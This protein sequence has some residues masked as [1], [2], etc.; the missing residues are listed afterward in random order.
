[1][2]FEKPT[3]RPQE[4]GVCGFLILGCLGLEGQ[5]LL[6]EGTQT[7][8]KGYLEEEG[9]WITG[10][11]QLWDPI[12][13]RAKECAVYASGLRA[14]G[15]MTVRTEAPDLLSIEQEGD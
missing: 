5:K 4:A 8:L 1:M 11:F 13:S 12:F 7:R 14:V 9:D 3:F 6:S 15:R 10:L 2:L